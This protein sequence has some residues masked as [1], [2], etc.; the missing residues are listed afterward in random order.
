MT[1]RGGI[2]HLASGRP[3]AS[4]EPSLMCLLLV[5]V[6]LSPVLVISS[7]TERTWTSTRLDQHIAREST[8]IMGLGFLQSPY[9]MNTNCSARAPLPKEVIIYFYHQ[10]R[11]VV[12]RIAISSG[13]VIKNTF[14][15]LI[16]H[17][18]PAAMAWGETSESAIKSGGL[19]RIKWA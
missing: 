17:P 15:C 12:C 19:L 3:W 7:T 10:Y 2:W 14:V 13:H 1:K 9:L 4:C 8:K 6:L 11:P 18:H 5:P 16:A